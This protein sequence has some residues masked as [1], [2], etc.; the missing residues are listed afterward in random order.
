MNKQIKLMVVLLA[1]VNVAIVG[2]LLLRSG[3]ETPSAVANTDAVL[4]DL[5]QDNTEAARWRPVGRC[6]QTQHHLHFH[7]CTCHDEPVLVAMAR[8][9]T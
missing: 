1:L 8:H 6:R 9:P 5:L 4:E 2:W 7:G 3:S